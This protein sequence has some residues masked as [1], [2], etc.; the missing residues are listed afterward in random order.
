MIPAGKRETVLDTLDDEGIDY[1]V[2]DETSGRE[3]TAV[4][5]FPLPRNAVEP[6]LDRLRE[7]G[8]DDSSYTIVLQAETVLSEH[9]EKLQERYEENNE[10]GQRISREE[11]RAG[12]SDLVPGFRTYIT[13]AVVSAIVATAGLLLDSPAVVVGSMVI[14][15]VLGPAMA[16]SV[17]S[18]INDNDLFKQGVKYQIIG[19]SAAV[20]AATAFAVLVKSLFLVPPGLDV[21]ELDQVQGRLSPD[22]LSLAVALG[23]GIAGAMSLSGGISAALVGVMIAAALIPPVAAV[24]IGIAWGLPDIVLGAGVLVLVNLFSINLA[25][26]AVLWYMG[27]RPEQWYKKDEART[28]TLRR[29]G[30]LIVGLLLLSGFLAGITVSSYQTATSDQAIRD[31]VNSVTDDEEYA[32][33]TLIEVQIQRTGSTF[34]AK[35]DQVLITIGHPTDE[36]HPGLAGKIRES[37]RNETGNNVSVQVQFVAVQNAGGG[38]ERVLSPDP[39]RRNA[40]HARPVT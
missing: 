7:V 13:L 29:M 20:V 10:S 6:V 23:G 17:G 18:V 22:L 9:F 31:Q 1:A 34:G 16:T 4:V 24:G 26:L 33:L 35:P 21:L 25:A 8:I 3:Y 2:T 19:F 40:I 11:I 30:T 39:P 15:P 28:K 14:A 5:S 12:A 36:Q 32:N 38:S 37:V 27:Y